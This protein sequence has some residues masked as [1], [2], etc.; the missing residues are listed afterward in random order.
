MNE[1]SSESRNATAAA[2]SDGWPSRFI[3]CRPSIIFR[4]TSGSWESAISRSTSGVAVAPGCTALQR[5]PCVAYST[6]I[7][8]TIAPTA[9]FE[10]E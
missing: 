7:A 2:I 6:P 9:A 3:I 8:R 10:I 4:C 5:M 1:A